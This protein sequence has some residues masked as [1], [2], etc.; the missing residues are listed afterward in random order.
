MNPNPSPPTSLFG[1]D[2]REDQ[3]DRNTLGE[4]RPTAASP[5]QGGGASPKLHLQPISFKE[6]SLFTRLHHRHHN[7]PQGHKFS[8]ALND[9]QQVVGVVMVGRPVARMLDDGSTLEVIRLCTNGSRNA[10]SMLYATAWKA[11]RAM[12]YQRLITYTT[13][14]EGGASLRASGWKLIGATAGGQWGRPSRPRLNV[15]DPGAKTLWEAPND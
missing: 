15:R 3:T 14:K 6:A 12:G 8:V 5:N 1:P 2:F 4:A 11:T 7:P 13:E 9:G 10:C